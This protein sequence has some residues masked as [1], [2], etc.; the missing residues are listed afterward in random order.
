MHSNIEFFDQIRL[1]KDM[2]SRSKR[3]LTVEYRKVGQSC[4]NIRGDKSPN[5]PV[6]NAKDKKNGLF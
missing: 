6:I 5:E 1:L 4:K 3:R 2:Y